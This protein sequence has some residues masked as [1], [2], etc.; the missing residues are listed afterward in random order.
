MDWTRGRTI[1]RGSTATVFVA[2]VDQSRVFAVKSS[3]L[4]LSESLRKEQ[5]ILSTLSCPHVVGYK[6][7]DISSENG[8]LLYNLFLEY[9]PRGTVMD[10]IQKHGGYL[11]EATV[12]SYTRGILLGLEFLHSRGIVHCDIKGQNVL[13]TD[14]GVKIADLGC[15][16]RA[17]EASSAAWSIAG[18]PVYMAPEVAR[19][20]Q[21]GCS[22]DVWALGCTVIEMAAGRSPWPDVSDPV[23]ALYRI[24]FSSDVP[25]IPTNISKQAQDFLSKCLRRDPADRWSATQLLSHDFV[26]ESKFPVKETDGSKSETPNNVLHPNIWDS[27]E[28]LETVQIPSNKPIME[29]LRQL[30]EDNLVLSSKIPNWEC[31]E[32]WLTVRSNSN[33]EV[34]K[35][36]STSRQDS[37]LLRADEP[38]SS[39]GGYTSRTSEDF[40]ILVDCF[41]TKIRR[42]NTRITNS[43]S[44][45][46]RSKTGSFAAFSFN[47]FEF[48]NGDRRV[49][50]SKDASSGELLFLVKLRALEWVKA[51][52]NKEVCDRLIVK[53]GG[54][55]WVPSLAV[56][57]LSNDNRVVGLFWCPFNSNNPNVTKLWAI[58]VAL[59]IPSLSWLKISREANRMADNLAK[60]V[61]FL[62]SV[63]DLL[64]CLVPMLSVFIIIWAGFLNAGGAKITVF[65]QKNLPMHLLRCVRVQYLPWL[66][67][68]AE[69]ALRGMNCL[70]K[71][72]SRLKLG[73]W[74]SETKLLDLCTWGS[75]C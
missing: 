63:C 1:G 31:D 35:L 14:D 55:I 3:E 50:E 20:E 56:W 65:S 22:A 59:E 72:S 37:N 25:E 57:L 38:T 41:L 12:R 8:K 19:G 74:S 48:Y 47:E 27:M 51:I 45:E 70:N 28:E 2:T 42:Q 53:G 18:T 7:C 24:G 62:A 43:D 9:A 68:W 34:E 71:R 61:V 13:V 16:R 15:A 67:Y 44:V 11:E 39:C 64:S 46:S 6:G 30:G 21:Q 58:K 33:L 54:F 5:R 17:D 36:P 52:E 4:S 69:S 32:N 66:L 29:R 60:S 10:A 73:R 26:V 23:S 49:F 40:E 75:D